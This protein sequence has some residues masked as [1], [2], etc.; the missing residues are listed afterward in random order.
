[1]DFSVVGLRKYIDLDKYGIS[2]FGLKLIA[3]ITMVIDHC[4][5][6]FVLDNRILHLAMRGIGRLSFPIYCF[7]LVEGFMHTKS[8]FKHALTLFVFAIISEIPYDMFNGYLFSMKKQNVIITLFI[9][10]L[11]IWAYDSILMSRDE[12]T[13]QPV[14][15]V[16]ANIF[17][18]IMALIAIGVGLY[19]AYMI[20]PTY[21]IAGVLLI[22]LFYIFYRKPM[23]RIVGN[24]FFNLGLYKPSIQWLGVASV[25]VI[26]FYNGKPG[27]RK[28]KY[29]FYIFYPLH[30]FILAVIKYIL[31][32]HNII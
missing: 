23:L 16:D 17:D 22:L 32:K 27:K 11:V 5:I 24:A 29:F 7:L 3:A 1:M 18:R 13:G 4:A 30:L 25:A 12:R 15:R 28:W 26:E 9:G 19:L 2:S 31:V 6:L 14:S 8:R 21:D 20:K 10:F